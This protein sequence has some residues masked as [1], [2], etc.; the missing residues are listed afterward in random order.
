MPSYEHLTL[1]ERCSLYLLHK[2][3]RGVCD[4]AR[5]LR[6]SPSTISRELKRNLD[7]DGRYN[8]HNATFAY[9]RRRKNCRRSFRYQMNPQL[10]SWTAGCLEKFWSP[11][12]IAAIWVREHPRERLGHSTIYR[13]IKS[14]LLPGIT[15]RTH[16]RRRGKRKFKTQKPQDCAPV[17]VDRRI[18]QWPKEV[19]A[20]SRIGDW[21]GDTVYGAP[22]KGVVLT[23]VDRASRCLVA[24]IC[25]NRGAD[26]IK[27]TILT[28]MKKRP[29]ST[30]SFDNAAEFAQYHQIEARLGIPIFF[31]D[32]HSPWQRGT[33]ENTNGI[34]RFFFPKGTNFL[35]V[36]PSELES[37]VSLINNRP[38]KCLGWLSP[39][40]V[41]FAYYCT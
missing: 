11:E 28:C 39:F 12:T 38:R 15:E 30:I 4:I 20:R 16:L 10:A 31:A 34:L 5:E 2:Q 23:L 33:N 21:E 40:D 8:Y 25:P 36:S 37:V 26:S 3:G 27:D 7:K 14:G 19:I 9:M 41:F 32:P 17:K 22:G 1:T 29:V 18:R 6:R 35:D 13:A 24:K